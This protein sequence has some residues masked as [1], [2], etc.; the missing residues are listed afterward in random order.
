MYTVR[1][2]LR[3]V[4]TLAYKYELLD[5]PYQCNFHQNWIKQ[6]CQMVVLGILH[7]FETLACKHELLV[8]EY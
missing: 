3:G 5:M 4:Q 1:R 6:G 8:F 7:G 2:I